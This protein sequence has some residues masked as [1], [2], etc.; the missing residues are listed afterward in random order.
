MAGGCDSR[1]TEQ[2]MALMGL[3]DTREVEEFAEGL[4]AD[5]GRRFPPI[6]EG[7]TDPGAKHQLEVITEGL[8]AR[9]IR[10]HQEHKLGVFKKAKL[11]NV[12]RWKLSDLGY[13][14]D[15][16]E[17]VTKTLARRLAAR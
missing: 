8:V 17:R 15:L 11:A 2:A 3:I 1:R 6:S 5:F 12:F 13:S 14:K 7:R 16:V 10:F 4:A 9:A